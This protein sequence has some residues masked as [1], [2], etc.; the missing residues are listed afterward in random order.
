MD[1]EAVED[2]FNVDN[3]VPTTF[4]LINQV[5]CGMVLLPENN[6]YDTNDDIDE[7]RATN[8]FYR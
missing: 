5:I 8:I 2:Y 6:D 1:E 7:L 3:D 4:S